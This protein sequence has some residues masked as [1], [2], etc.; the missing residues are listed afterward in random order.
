MLVMLIIVDRSIFISC[1]IETQQWYKKD[2]FTMGSNNFGI[3]MCEKE[4]LTQSQSKSTITR[5]V[6]CKFNCITVLFTVI[7]C[8]H[9]TNS[10]NFQKLLL[11]LFTKTCKLHQLIFQQTTFEWDRIIAGI[12]RRFV[13]FAEAG[14]HDSPNTKITKITQN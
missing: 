11:I 12:W 5:S 7:N 2:L 4:E 13:F 1:H 14:K 10:E 3:G 8:Q 9:R 6:H